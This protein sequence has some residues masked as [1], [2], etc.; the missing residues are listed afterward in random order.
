MASPNSPTR[1]R[2]HR[3]EFGLV[4]VGLDHALL[5]VVQHHVQGAAAEVAKRLLVQLGPHLLAGLPDHP[6][7]TAPRVAHCG[8][9]QAWLLVAIGAGRQGRCA[10]AVIDLHLFAG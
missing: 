5:E 6:A 1:G 4:Q 2:I 10:F 8:D 9:K 3:V 7:E